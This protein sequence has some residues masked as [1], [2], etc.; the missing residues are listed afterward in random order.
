MTSEKVKYPR[1]LAIEAVREI[2]AMFQAGCRRVVVA[3]SLRRMKEEVG[4]VEI[5]YL[6]NFAEV[7]ADWFSTRRV[8]VADRVLD[9]ML[10]SGLIAKRR[11]VLFQESWG[12]QNKY[13]V[14]VTSGIPVDFFETY[15]EAWFNYLVC[16]TGGAESNMRV[17]SAAQ[18]KGWKWHPYGIG[19]H[20]EQGNT[21]R[22]GSER[23][24]FEL[25]G[26]PFLE[27]KER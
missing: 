24:V 20:D 23:E 1:G 3:G 18:A 12:S 10:A 13:A 8:N 7:K 21:V 4:D 27:P 17:A 5:L 19:F 11:N 22:V 15:E 25:V 26:L 6:P 14:H 16:R 2:L 9:T